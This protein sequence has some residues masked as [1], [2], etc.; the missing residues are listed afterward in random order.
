[1]S[2]TCGKEKNR[3]TILAGYQ[4]PGVKC[5]DQD[6]AIVTLASLDLMYCF[7]PFLPFLF[8]LPGPQ[9]M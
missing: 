4:G 1:M 5:A 9:S 8:F 3:H 2:D 7:N 6:M